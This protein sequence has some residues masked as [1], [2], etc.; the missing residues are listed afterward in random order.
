MLRALPVV[1]AL[2]AGPAVAQETG[3]AQEPPVAFPAEIEQVTVDVVIIDKD[4]GQPIT[5][6]TATDIEVYED[7]KRQTIS[8]FDM[9]EV[10]PPPADEAEPT[11]GPAEAAPPV[12]RPAPRTRVSTN[13]D[14]DD[15]QGRT[16]MI[17]FDDVHTTPRNAPAA[18]AATA[19]FV[20]EQ[21]AEGDRV[22]LVA[23]GAGVWRNG[24]MPEDREELLEALQ[25]LEALYIPDT[26]RD[27]MSDYEA[28]RIHNFR[29][30]EVLNRV[31]RRYAKFFVQTAR[32][33][34]PHTRDFRNEQDPYITS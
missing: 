31:E 24:R 8:A 19:K 26:A 27:R 23:P 18:R 30:Y 25:G 34:D 5:D 17:V 28:M 15:R 14:K 20:N 6:L 4:T 10:A 11:E 7:G 16:F 1:L 29:D 21:T 3:A 2:V 12:K 13:L 22:T 32:E 9:F 33:L